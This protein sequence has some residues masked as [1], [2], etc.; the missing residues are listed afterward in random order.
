[1]FLGLVLS[2]HVETTCTILLRGGDWGP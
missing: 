1:L 2:L